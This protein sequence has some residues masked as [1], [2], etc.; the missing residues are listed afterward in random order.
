MSRARNARGSR[1]PLQRRIQAWA[2]RSMWTLLIWGLFLLLV[3]GPLLT[4]LAFS[5]TSSV[6]EGVRPVTLKWYARLLTEPELYAPIIRSFEVAL[7][8]VIVQLLFG[9]LIAYAA[10]RRHVFAAPTLDAMS[11]LTIALPSVVVGLALLSFYGP[12]GPIQAL[13]E[14]LFTHPFAITWTLWIVVFAHV[15]ETFPYMVRTVTSVLQ[16][17]NPHLE[18]AARSLGARRWTVFRTIVLPQ[19]RPGLLAGGVLV[20][21]RSIAE[22]GATV[23]V[24]SAAL[25]T[26]PIKIFSEAEAGSL[27]L[28]AAYSVVLMLASFAVYLFMRRRVLGAEARVAAQE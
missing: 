4:V 26:A 1:T 18:S 19:L 12:F 20:F 17:M 22:F 24:V 27:E 9:T 15:L 5:F 6:F 16:R 3:M 21:S 8:V 11:N 7:L 28:A 2:E 23:I 10:V 13:S 25:R 14:F